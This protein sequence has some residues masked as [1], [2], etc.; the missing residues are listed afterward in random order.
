MVAP[1]NTDVTLGMPTL[2]QEGIV[3]DAANRDIVTPEMEAE[4]KN[5]S[6]RVGCEILNVTTGNPT[7]I[8]PTQQKSSSA[9]RAQADAPTIMPEAAKKHHA[10]CIEEFSDVFNH[11]T[12]TLDSHNRPKDAPYHRIQLKDPNK[13]I[14]R[15]MF[16]LPE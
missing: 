9:G 16:A 4:T 12:P 1:L 5:K 7:Q 11:K 2:Q 3:V 15:R 10:E 13:S 8:K 6:T 14:N